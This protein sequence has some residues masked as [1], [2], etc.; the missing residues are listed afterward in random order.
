MKVFKF[1]GA[2]VKNADAVRNVAKV[3][4]RYPNDDLCIIVSAM[5]K[6]TNALE[7]VVEQYINR[8]NACLE[9]LQKIADFHN[10]IIA[11]LFPQGHLELESSIK[12]ILDYLSVS[13]QEDE[14][15]D[16]DFEYDQ[17]VG[18]GEVLSTRIVS[19]YLA[20][21]G[22][23]NQ[24]FDARMFIRTDMQYRN[25]R[26]DWD[27]TARLIST[28]LYPF[29][30][31]NETGGRSVA[32][33]QGFIAQS[34]DGTYTTLGREGSDFT[35]AIITHLMEAE[36]LT[37]W[38]DVPGVLNADPKHFD[39]PSL[40]PHISYREA[41]ELSYYGATIIHPKT[42]KPLENKDVPLYVK[43][44]VNPDQDGTRIDSS[45]ED[46]R[47]NPS[48]IVK[49][50]QILISVT[51][52]DFSFIVERNL[53]DIFE[54][55]ARAKVKISLIQNSAINFSACVDVDRNRV[56]EAI[57]DLQEKYRVR[58][59][60]EVELLTIRHYDQGL[61]DKL[62]EGKEV[63]V[64]QRTRETARFVQRIPRQN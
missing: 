42:I 51:P 6:T 30:D 18:W 47:K 61:I 28:T 1:G 15:V 20:H 9:S 57:K 37:V 22:I 14:V 29:F 23:N 19:A 21:C 16:F 5:G 50:Q 11:D 48:F 33:T 38:K 10:E 64:Q 27:E 25:A 43:S 36:S 24:W 4:E 54:T 39:D 2:S 8:D 32:I 41:I 17:F 62:T 60:E 13:L 35:G 49:P 40:L 44:F 31:S 26:V 56:D 7:I 59:N 52:K 46:D 58:Y 55:F 12:S 63:L 34:D 53:S 3:I 45:M